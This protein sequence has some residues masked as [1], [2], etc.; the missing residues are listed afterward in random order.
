M[1]ARLITVLVATVTIAVEATPVRRQFDLQCVS[2]DPVILAL[3]SLP[4]ATPFCS[5][6]LDILTATVTSTT[7]LDALTTQ[8]ITSTAT[9]S[10]ILTGQISTI[11]SYV[12]SSPISVSEL[13]IARTETLTVCSLNPLKK[14]EDCTEEEGQAT[15]PVEQ[16]GY[17]TKTESHPYQTAETEVDPEYNYWNPHYDTEGSSKDPEYKTS[18]KEPEPE[19]QYY[20]AQQYNTQHYNTHTQQASPIATYP[21]P[22]PR[23][24][25]GYSSN[26]ISD[27]FTNTHT[28]PSYGF[29]S[30]ENSDTFVS[31]HTTHNPPPY[32]SSSNIVSDTFTITPPDT[33]TP[34]TRITITTTKTIVTNVPTALSQFDPTDLLYGC[35]CLSLPTPTVTFTATATDAPTATEVVTVSTTSAA[36]LPDLVLTATTTVTVSACATPPTTCNNLGVQWAEYRN[37]LERPG[38]DANYSAFLPEVYK[39]QTPEIPGVYGNIGPVDFTSTRSRLVTIYDSNQAF[40]SAFFALDHKAYFFAPVAGRYV[41]SVT[42]VDDAVFLW[43]GPQAYAGWTRANADGFGVY[44]EGAGFARVVADLAAGEYVPVR[45]MLAQ[46]QGP[47]SFNFYVAA[48]D[49]TNIVSPDVPDSPY[50]VQFSCDGVTAPAFVDWPLET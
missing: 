40:P 24:T 31:T 21:Y 2:Q 18:S 6:L 35:S 33:T 49:G 9:Q 39:G 14:R 26:E 34:S 11:T 44:D 13:T 1:F 29:S 42:N 4:V 16:P 46:S 48:P 12:M 47:A 50:L 45:L 38:N 17:G 25:Y 15:A 3:Q 30:F 8:T 43:L 32:G 7:A 22:H 37:F 27:T 5:S 41:F 20:H 28:R 10:T 23:P 19:S 36:S